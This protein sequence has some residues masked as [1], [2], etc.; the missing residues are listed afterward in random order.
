MQQS[1]DLQQP[2]AADVD[3]VT[4][5]GQEAPVLNA[6]ERFRKARGRIDLEFVLEILQAYGAKFKL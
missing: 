4:I 3:P 5:D 6:L 1:V 2:F